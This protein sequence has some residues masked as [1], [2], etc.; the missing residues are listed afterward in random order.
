MEARKHIEPAKKA[1]DL[2]I[3]PALVS[4]NISMSAQTIHQTPDVVLEQFLSD[5]I[6][7]YRY[8][9]SAIKQTGK[10]EEQVL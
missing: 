1:I 7:F 6:R 9:T 5:W 2:T 4:I 3:C 10:K 8:R